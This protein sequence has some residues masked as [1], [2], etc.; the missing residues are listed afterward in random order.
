MNAL[1]SLVSLSLPE[2]VFREVDAGQLYVGDEERIALAI[3]LANRNVEEKTG[4]PFGAAVFTREGKLV[5]VGVNRVVPQHCSVAHA[6]MMAYM[7]AQSRLGRFRLNEA[8]PGEAPTEYVLATSAQ[9]CCQCYGATVWAGIGEL[10]IGARSEDVEE[11]SEFDEGPLPADWIGELAKRGVQVKRD[12]LRD[13]ARAVFVH[14][15]AA[16]GVNY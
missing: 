16:G 3:R 4:G 13:A 1:P 9:P 14:Y 7:L 12:I 10:L 15:R 8:A 5:S 6:E 2:W 11:L